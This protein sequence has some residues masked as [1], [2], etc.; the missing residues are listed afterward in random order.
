LY[1]VVTFVCSTF[2]ND[3]RVFIIC[4]IAFFS[5]FLGTIEGGKKNKG[6]RLRKS[7]EGERTCVCEKERVHMY[8]PQG[9]CEEDQ[10]IRIPKLE[11]LLSMIKLP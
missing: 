7:E 6:L 8:I 4:V 1:Q 2:N 3:Q 5:I 11:L 10:P 9:I